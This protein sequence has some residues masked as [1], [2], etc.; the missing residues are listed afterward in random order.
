MYHI[1]HNTTPY[2]YIKVDKKIALEGL[3]NKGICS[4]NQL[5]LLRKSGEGGFFACELH[6]TCLEEAAR[7]LEAIGMQDVTITKDLA[8]RNRIITARKA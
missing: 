5:R 7:R 8:G 2:N 6:E 1:Q 4:G 3:V